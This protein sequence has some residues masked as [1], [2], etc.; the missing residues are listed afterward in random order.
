[1]LASNGALR[2]RMSGNAGLNG[3]FASGLAAVADIDGDGSL[4]VVAGA[5]AYS[6]SGAVLWRNDAIGDGY[7]AIADFDA[8]GLPEI[9][10]VRSGVTVLRADGSVFWGPRALPGGGEGGAPTVGDFDGDGRPEIGVAGASTYTAFDTDGSVLWSAPTQDGTSRVTGSTVFDLEA[11]VASKCFT[12]TA[13][14]PH[15]RR[16]PVQAP[17][18]VPPVARH[19]SIR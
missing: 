7:T 17:S 12:T 1:M 19:S 4:D 15:F 9:V 16:R 14:L 18:R 5:M 11:M 3:A 6:A 8:D 10:V 2:W 13:L